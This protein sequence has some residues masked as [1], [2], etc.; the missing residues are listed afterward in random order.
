MTTPQA[1]PQEPQ[2]DTEYGGGY[3]GYREGGYYP[4]HS[5]PS[6]ASEPPPLPGTLTGT[7]F[8]SNTSVIGLTRLSA[9]WKGSNDSSD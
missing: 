8:W 1:D 5:Y 9:W 3:S 2:W 6:L 4:S 7:L